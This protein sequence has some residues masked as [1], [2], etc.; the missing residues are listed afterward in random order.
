MPEYIMSKQTKLK[1]TT[2][3]AIK[4]KCDSFLSDRKN[5][6]NIV[7]ILSSL[8]VIQ[9]FHTRF[10][11]Q[12]SRAQARTQ[13]GG[14]G[15]RRPPPTPKVPLI[16]LEIPKIQKFSRSLRSPTH[17]LYFFSH[18]VGLQNV[19]IINNQGGTLNLPL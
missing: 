16:F 11:V 7:E 17:F 8:E 1:I 10:E 19:Y 9:I 14:Q 12:S 4:Q 6:N 15:G 2:K 13:G 3:A 18:K 5:A